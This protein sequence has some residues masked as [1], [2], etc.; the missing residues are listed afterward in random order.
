[1][2]H[3]LREWTHRILE[4]IQWIEDAIRTLQARS[5]PSLRWIRRRISTPLPASLSKKEFL[6]PSIRKNAPTVF[7]ATPLQTMSRASKRHLHLFTIQRG[8]RPDQQL[9]RSRR[10][11]SLC[12]KLNFD[13]CMQGRTLYV[14]PYSMG[15]LG[16]PFSHIG[17]QITDSPYVVCNMRIMTRMGNEVLKTLGQ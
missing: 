14:I 8:C 10:D 1:M 11:A 4:L 15:P 13:G 6:F 12:S 9:A 5:S 2:T 17:V 16:S 3:S 7:G